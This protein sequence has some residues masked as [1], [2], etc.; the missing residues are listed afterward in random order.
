MGSLLLFGSSLCF[1][2]SLLA[3]FIAFIL[4]DI[5]ENGYSATVCAG[6]FIGLNYFWGGFAWLSIFTWASVGSYL[7]AGFLF[8]L[9]RTYFKG[10]EFKESRESYSRGTEE[11]ELKT[12][13]DS[14]GNSKESFDLKGNVF[15]W[16]FLFP[17]SALTWIFGHLFV[18]LWNLVYS[19]VEKMYQF[20]F[21]GVNKEVKK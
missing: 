7:F 9:I 12:G 20:L 15:R 10:K 2:L 5:Y 16:W 19:K 8:S 11:K 21:Y 14:Y 17:I 1:S 13:Y 18:D 6:I 3:L 4:A